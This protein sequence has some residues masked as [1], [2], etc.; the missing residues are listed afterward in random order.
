M[1]VSRVLRLGGPVV[2]NH[3][4]LALMQLTDA[5][6]AGSLSSSALAAITPASLLITLLSI[7]GI[8]ALTGVTTH[9]AQSSGRKRFSACGLYAWQ[10][11][12]CGLLYGLI[13]LMYYPAGEWIFRMLLPAHSVELRALEAEYFQISLLGLVP[14]MI[15]VA[16]GNFFTGTSRTLPTVVATVT[17][18]VMN[19]VASLLLVYGW[20]GGSGGGIGFS[21]IAWGTVIASYAQMAVMLAMFLGPASNRIT[22]AT[23]K[24]RV[25][26]KRIALLL[27]TGL[28][29][30][31]HG[32]VDFMAWGLVLTW[33]V[34]FFGEAHLAAQTIMVRCITLS[35]L[36]A[37]GMAT[38]LT[39]LVGQAI[40]AR[41]FAQARG[42]TRAAFVIIATWMSGMAVLYAVFRDPLLRL[43]TDDPEVIEAGRGAILWVAAFQFFDAMNVT[44]TNALQGADDTAWPGAVNLVLSVVVLLGGG[45]AVVTWLPWSA[46]QGVWAVATLY[47][48]CQGVLFYLRWRSGKWHPLAGPAGRRTV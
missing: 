29:A 28:P 23:G 27:R 42:V 25:S 19:P 10:G 7:F 45:L 40:G 11:I 12:I 46:S 18:A 31:V 20:P 21:G 33:L 2:V 38:A 24:I 26:W 5:W 48:I 13:C 34:G 47:I 36:P 16:A 3:A 1:N 8:E 37:D 35:F 44:Y 9:V 22:H 39:T 4:S 41:N 6:I 17:A 30:G 32:C 14:Q 43:F 15:T